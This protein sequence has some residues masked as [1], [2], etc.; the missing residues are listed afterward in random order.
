M[1]FISGLRLV[2]AAIMIAVAGLGSFAAYLFFP[3]ARM[4][5]ESFLDTASPGYQLGLAHEAIAQ[6]GLLGKGPFEGNVK[7][8]LPDPHT[9]FI[10]AVASEEFGFVA[11]LGLLIVFAV[12]TLR[13]IQ[14]GSIRAGAFPRAAGTALF[15]LFGFQALI[16][17]GV[18]LGLLPTK[19]MTLPFISYGGS[20]MIG[21][22]IT[23]GFALALTRR[24]AEYH[25]GH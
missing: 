16:N 25:A 1:V 13:G 10:Y 19:G 2:T 21:T 4:R 8:A 20:S 6:G 11:C 12:I 3:H 22:A 7:S 9:D 5:I 24:R 17:T 18:N 23:L 14:A 15:C